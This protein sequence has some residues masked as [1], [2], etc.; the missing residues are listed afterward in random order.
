MN[1]DKRQNERYSTRRRSKTKQN[2]QQNAR[3]Q[4]L[5]LIKFQANKLIKN[6]HE[7]NLKNVR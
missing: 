6:K 5:K 4:T 1:P 2:W 3:E 7:K